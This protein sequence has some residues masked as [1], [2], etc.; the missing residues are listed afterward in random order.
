MLQCWLEMMPSTGCCSARLAR[1]A[2][3]AAA[4]CWVSSARRRRRL[5]APMAAAVLLVKG[6]KGGSDRVSCFHRAATSHTSMA[7][8]DTRCGGGAEDKGGAVQDLVQLCKGQ[9]DTLNTTPAPR[10]AHAAAL[11]SPH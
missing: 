11:M 10:P 4:A 2:A 5:G 1:A 8:Q 3:T 6:G 7:T 9:A